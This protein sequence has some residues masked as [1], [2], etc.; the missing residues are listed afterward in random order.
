M[1]RVRG[2]LAISAMLLA[3]AFPAFAQGVPGIP[4]GAEAGEL[5]EQIAAEDTAPE[6]SANLPPPSENAIVVRGLRE[7]KSSWNR[8]E[9]EHAVLYSNGS[10]GDLRRVGQTLLSLDALLT[11]LFGA[12]EPEFERNKLTITMIGG[13][14]FVE[15]MRLDTDHVQA[16]RF[17]VPFDTQR[18]YQPSSYR[19]LLGVSRRD[20]IFDA[21]ELYQDDAFDVFVD[22]FGFDDRDDLFDNSDLFNDGVNTGFGD[23]AFFD[24]VNSRSLNRHIGDIGRSSFSQRNRNQRDLSPVRRPWESIMYGSYAEHF[25]LS[26]FPA[27][28][29]RWYLDGISALFSSTKVRGDGRVEYGRLPEDFHKVLPSYPPLQTGPILTASWLSAERDADGEGEGGVV[30]TPYH[31]A[32]LVHYFIINP[33]AGERQ[34]Q[35]LQYLS[36]ITEGA[37]PAQAAEVFG[38]FA[39]LDRELEEYRRTGLRYQLITLSRDIE[40]LYDPVP[41]SIGEAETLQSAVLLES[42]ILPPQDPDGM[43]LEN[44]QMRDAYLQ[45]LRQVVADNPAETEILLLL[46]EAECRAG[47]ARAC[48]AAADRLLA[49]EGDNSRA[50]AWRGYALLALAPEGDAEALRTARRAI[51]AANRADTEAT[52]PL[53]TY[54]R[55]FA[56][57]GEEIPD[58][59]LLG[60]VKVIA[61]IPS[62]LEPRLMLGREFIAREQFAAAR[63]LLLP[64]LNAELGSDERARAL[65]LLADIPAN[66]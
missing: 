24:D 14:Y 41:I 64:V 5:V 27:H 46:A 20:Q 54:Y 48:L 47:N 43:V 39:V 31:A 57:R 12:G 23:D 66:G 8:L 56:E 40:K 22:G 63:E 35:F 29:S 53:L 58:M 25:L 32:L 10:S 19:M 62:A 33:D 65:E 51:I 44:Q 50:M 37:E 55:S 38:D 2:S 21:T 6:V 7:R 42:R 34:V 52:L 60:M 15:R 36:Q 4:D 61:K 16:S 45:D 30:W 9:T 11:Q 3:G 1:S 28:Y 49:M 13:A 17:A 18:F 26:A 59:A